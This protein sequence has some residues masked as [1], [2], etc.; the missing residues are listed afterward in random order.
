MVIDDAIEEYARQHSTPEPPHL[1]EY[2]TTNLREGMVL[3][4]EPATYT[5]AGMFHAEQVVLVT[6]S[7]GEILSPTPQALTGLPDPHPQ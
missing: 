3:T 2:D 7:G 1:A 4:V 6:G 5:D